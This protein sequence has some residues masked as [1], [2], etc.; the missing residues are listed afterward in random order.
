MWLLFQFVEFR[1]YTHLS[2][3]QL[4]FIDDW[5]RAKDERDNIDAILLDFEKALDSV[6]H[7]ILIF[8]LDQLQVVV[9]DFQVIGSLFRIN[10]VPQGSIVGPT[11]YL[12]FI[13]SETFPDYV[14]SSTK[15]FSDAT[16]LYHKANTW[17]SVINSR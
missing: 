8:K 2:A 3:H 15:L 6:P 14:K 1:I 11:L 12:L 9:G 4:E 10:R 17:K 5:T 16:K 13:N 7:R